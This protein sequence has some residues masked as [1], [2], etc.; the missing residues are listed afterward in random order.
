[1]CLPPSNK[2]KMRFHIVETNS[3]QLRYTRPEGNPEAF[4]NLSAA[5]FQHQLVMNAVSTGS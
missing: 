1:M 4:P 3:F 2:D 5:Y